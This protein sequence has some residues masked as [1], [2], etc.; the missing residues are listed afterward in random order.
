MGI[1]PYTDQYFDGQFEWLGSP[2]V[3]LGKTDSVPQLGLNFLPNWFCP[4][5]KRKKKNLLPAEQML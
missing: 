3:G 1:C 4:L 5:L 2:S